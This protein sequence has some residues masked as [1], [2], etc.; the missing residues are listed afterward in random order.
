MLNVR[1]RLAYSSEN[2]VVHLGVKTAIDCTLAHLGQDRGHCLFVQGL[3]RSGKTH[4]T[5]RLA[6]EIAR[7]GAFPRLFEPEEFSELLIA[8]TQ[9]DLHSDDVFIVDDVHIYFANVGP[10]ESGPFVN[11]IERLRA[12]GASIVLLSEL[13][14]AAL[15]CD[16][17]VMSRLR[18]GT[19]L[20]IGAPEEGDLPALIASLAR[21][22]GIALRRSH[23]EFL[24]KRVAKSVPW[25]VDYFERLAHLSNSLSRG[26]NTQDLQSILPQQSI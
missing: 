26:I 8:G 23:V 10:G 18:S 12:R 24:V 6:E 9:Q 3:P 17:H 25:L 11:L 13:E 20:V 15:P 16:A 5:L 22:R 4:L 14:I 2:F 1:P 19:G 21:Q 7:K